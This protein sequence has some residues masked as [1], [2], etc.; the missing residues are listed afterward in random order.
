MPRFVLV[1]VVLLVQ[2]AVLA[3]LSNGAARGAQAVSTLRVEQAEDAGASEVRALQEEDEDDDDESVAS[4]D[5]ADSEGDD[6]VDDDDDDEERRRALA[7][8]QWYPTAGNVMKSDCAPMRATDVVTCRL[9]DNICR[10]KYN[11]PLQWVGVGCKST[12]GGVKSGGGGCQC[13]LDSPG[14]SRL[15]YCKC[16]PCAAPRRG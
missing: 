15:Q 8:T 2:V 10:N 7:T 5:S 14:G 16:V 3:L 13:G 12:R 11:I 1:V 9:L 4:A 6:E